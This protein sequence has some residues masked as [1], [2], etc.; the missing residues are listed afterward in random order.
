MIANAAGALAVGVDIN[1]EAL[2][3]AKQLGAVHVLNSRSE[4]KLI[5]RIRELTHGG[6]HVAVD[7]L[8]SPETCKNS[9]L[10]L[11]KRGRHVQIGIPHAPPPAEVVPMLV[12]SVIATELRFIGSLGMQAHAYPAMLDM[13]DTGRLP[14]ERLIHDKVSLDR[15]GDV[16][17][18]MSEFRGLGVTVIDRFGEMTQR[19]SEVRA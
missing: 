3:L 15:A 12:D 19:F 17:T 18:R 9:L 10:S 14:V 2:A 6:A 5:E 16:L 7:A 11:R 4:P 8:G 13:M 1:A